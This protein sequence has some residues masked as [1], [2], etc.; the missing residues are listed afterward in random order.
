MGAQVELAD[1]RV[2]SEVDEIKVVERVVAGCVEYRVG[3]GG[4]KGL[5]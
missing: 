4:D 5:H 1:R 3:Q 2:D